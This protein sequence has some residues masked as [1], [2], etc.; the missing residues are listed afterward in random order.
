MMNELPGLVLALAIGAGLGVVFFGG[1][2]LTLLRVPTSRWPILLVLGSLV[3]RT[4]ITLAGFYQVMDGNW[5]RL[6]ACVVG[7]ALVRQWLIRRSVFQ[8]IVRGK[9]YGYQS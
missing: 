8:T 3:G 9:D 5:L 1:L 2:W 7:F 4:A 6:L